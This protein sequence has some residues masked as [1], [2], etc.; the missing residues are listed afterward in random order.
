MAQQTIQLPN[1][2]FRTRSLSAGVQASWSFP[3]TSRTEIID[4]LKDDASD[5]IVLFQFAL[6]ASNTIVLNITDSAG[7]ATGLDLSSAFETSGGIDVSF[8]GTTYSFEINSADRVAPYSWI[9]SNSSDVNTLRQAVIAASNRDATLV[10]RDGPK[11]VTPVL[12][13]ASAGTASVSINTVANGNEGTSVTLGAT[14]IKR[15]GVYDVVRYA[16]TV[17]AG[18][19]TGA[20][21]ATPH[22]DT[23]HG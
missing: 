17:S 14:L 15:T 13:D 22:M 11:T 3:S 4:D 1:S 2:V 23:S 19:L 8:G 18:T 12:P 9:P 7:S 5:S 21:T 16:W 10:I 20:N 6:S